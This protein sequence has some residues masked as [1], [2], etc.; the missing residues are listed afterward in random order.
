MWTLCFH[1]GLSAVRI[2]HFGPMC[3]VILSW[4]LI[5]AVA[6]DGG[7]QLAVGSGSTVVLYTRSIHKRLTWTTNRCLCSL[8]M[9]MAESWLSGISH[10]LPQPSLSILS[11]PLGGTHNSMTHVLFLFVKGGWHGLL[12]QSWTSDF[13]NPPS[14]ETDLLVAP[15]GSLTS[16]QCV[17]M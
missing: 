9:E 15:A 5:R 11:L 14:I 2:G 12:L 7:C 10:I 6:L 13:G 1:S 4:R 3:F 16:Y 8:Q 17:S